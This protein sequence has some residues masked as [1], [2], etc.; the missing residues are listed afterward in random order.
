MLFKSLDLLSVFFIR[1]FVFSLW[2]QKYQETGFINTLL[3]PLDEIAGTVQPALPV[4]RMLEGSWQC[5]FQQS[6]LGLDEIWDPS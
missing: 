1:V 4:D 3:L 6:M 2:E 5:P